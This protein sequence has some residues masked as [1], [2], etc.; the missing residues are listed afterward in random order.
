MA[1]SLPLWQYFVRKAASEVF[2]NYIYGSRN[3]KAN[4]A[5][6]GERWPTH[7]SRSNPLALQKGA[8][9]MIGCRNGPSLRFLRPSKCLP[10]QMEARDPD[11]RYGRLKGLKDSSEEN[12]SKIRLP[13]MLRKSGL[14]KSGL[15]TLHFIR[16]DPGMRSPAFGATK[17]DFREQRA[18]V[19]ARH[20]A[21]SC[22]TSS[23]K[24]G[25]LGSEHRSEPGCSIRI[26]RKTRYQHVR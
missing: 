8:S 15:R 5:N 26:W 21:A 11:E 22:C 12:V 7:R 2:K 14:R 4:I 3:V 20:S 6:S 10:P 9:R 17:P 19:V 13:T 23:W 16:N 18:V 24:C 25:L 1:S